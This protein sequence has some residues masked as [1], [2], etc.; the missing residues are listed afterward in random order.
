MGLF[1]AFK[2]KSKK[3]MSLP[4]PALK[5]VI[6]EDLPEFPVGVSQSNYVSK[7]SL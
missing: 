4:P 6:P 7:G 5:Q 3:E 2:S 1:D